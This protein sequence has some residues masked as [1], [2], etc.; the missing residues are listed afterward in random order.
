[1]SSIIEPH[2]RKC[3]GDA[4]DF[5]I[6]E[7]KASSITL[8][9]KNK[10]RAMALRKSRRIATKEL[11][12]KRSKLSAE[13]QAAHEKVDAIMAQIPSVP[14]SST[15]PLPA[16]PADSVEGGVD[17][18]SAINLTGYSIMSSPQLLK[19]YTPAVVSVPAGGI[20]GIPANLGP[21]NPTVVIIGSYVVDTF[22]FNVQAFSTKNGIPSMNIPDAKGNLVVTNPAL[23]NLYIYYANNTNT[24][25]ITD[26]SVPTYP[27]D[28]SA[29]NLETNLDIQGAHAIAPSVNIV[30][31]M[32]KES[33]SPGLAAAMKFAVS[34]KP[35]MNI[36]ATS[37]SWGGEESTM[38]IKIF[39]QVI[40]S[41]T[42]II[43]CASS[44][45]SGSQP[46]QTFPAALSGVVAC[47]G[48]SIVRLPGTTIFKS[49]GW[50]GAGGGIST[51][52]VKPSY[53]A[54]LP[55]LM[56]SVPDVG[57]DADPYTG[58]QLYLHGVLNPGGIGGT[59]LAAPL[60]AGLV[61]SAVQRY[62]ITNK[63]TTST[64]CIKQA[65]LFKFL[66]GGRS[67]TDVTVNDTSWS[68]DNSAQTTPG[69][70]FVTGLG[71]PLYANLLAMCTFTKL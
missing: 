55:Y 38:P 70:D 66:Y 46:L 27:V 19:Y 33:S 41:D 16:P 20:S 71:S 2:V 56:R 43:Y 14:P 13:E 42:N 52:V 28:S 67:T 65:D 24:G 34:L 25:F 3:Q 4:V 22:G 69:Y 21:T 50:N 6:A 54:Y 59:S 36:V 64:V 26:P 32:A 62:M 45:D 23:A 47:G 10:E 57:L 49:L 35:V 9:G 31:V 18:A 7:K 30:L 53:Q 29:W 44:G 68:W 39:N 48:T 63:I 5:L 12:L 1:M 51:T 8:K 15:I 37:M 58:I 60:M 11:N 17:V 40:E 61:A